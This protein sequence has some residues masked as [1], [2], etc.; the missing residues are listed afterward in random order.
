MSM[1]EAQVL[2]DWGPQPTVPTCF[3]SCSPAQ[4]CWVASTLPLAISMLYPR[5]TQS[6][7]PASSL[8]G[9]KSARVK[10]M[11]RGPYPIST[12]M[13]TMT[14]FAMRTK[15]WGAP[16]LKLAITTPHPPRTHTIH[17]ACTPPV[18]KP[19]QAKPTAPGPFLQRTTTRT[20]TGY[21]MTMRCSVAQTTP[22]ATTTPPL[23]P[24]PTTRSVFTPT[25]ARPAQARPTALARLWTTTTTAMACAMPTRSRDAPIRTPVITT[26]PPPPTPITRCASTR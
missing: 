25:A 20:T 16:M 24:T 12:T 1:R 5:P 19:A 13:W 15:Y 18:V 10:P 8:K 3:S 9:V 23:P 2:M 22:P 26:P 17:C 7:P 6:L 4:I 21:A 11:E 14:A